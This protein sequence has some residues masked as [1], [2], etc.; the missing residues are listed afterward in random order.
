MQKYLV[1]TQSKWLKNPCKLCDVRGI[2]FDRANDIATQMGVY[3][4]I[5]LE[6]CA[7]HIL[8][9]DRR[10][11]VIPRWQLLNCPEECGFKNNKEKLDVI[12]DMV[13]RRQIE[14]SNYREDIYAQH[15][16]Y[17]SAEKLIASDLERIR[18]ATSSLGQL[19]HDE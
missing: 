11:R 1:K 19:K 12:S 8:A 7:N 10:S 14:Q 6:A 4:L 3:K 18:S 13:E 16:S 15:L 5:R 2:S 17:A 9:S